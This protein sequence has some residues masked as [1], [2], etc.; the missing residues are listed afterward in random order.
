M[1][2]SFYSVQ[3]SGYLPGRCCDGCLLTCMTPSDVDTAQTT[4]KKD[5]QRE[6]EVCLHVN[7]IKIPLRAQVVNFSREKYTFSI[8]FSLTHICVILKNLLMKV[9]LVP[10]TKEPSGRSRRTPIQRNLEMLLNIQHTTRYYNGFD[11]EDG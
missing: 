8:L 3:P 4:G 10:E 9:C 2:S 7:E 1:Y 6:Y 11:E 5:R